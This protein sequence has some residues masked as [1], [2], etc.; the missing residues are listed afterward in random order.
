M[1]PS[2]GCNLCSAFPKGGISQ[3]E[4]LCLRMGSAAPLQAR[5]SFRNSLKR[6]ARAGEEREELIVRSP[7]WM[8]AK[9]APPRPRSQAAWSLGHNP[10]AA[11]APS[12]PDLCP[13]LLGRVTDS[14]GMLCI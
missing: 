7:Q 4:W 5:Y 8:C 11:F 6:R 10:S 12:P 2:T 13:L 9:G 3:E 1:G 14:G